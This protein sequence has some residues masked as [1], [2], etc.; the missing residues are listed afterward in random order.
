MIEVV[1]TGNVTIVDAAEGRCEDG[2]LGCRIEGAT[3]SLL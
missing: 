1:G 3:L 2:P